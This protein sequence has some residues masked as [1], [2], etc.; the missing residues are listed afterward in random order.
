MIT[1]A[2]EHAV[3]LAERSDEFY[4]Y[5][6]GQHKVAIGISRD[7]I[8]FTWDIRTNDVIVHA[9]HYRNG[10]GSYLLWLLQEIQR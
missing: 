7:E 9:E 6:V 5:T 1:I 4:A 3:E 2:Q 8:H 10:R